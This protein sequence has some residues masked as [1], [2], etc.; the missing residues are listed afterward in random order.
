MKKCPSESSELVN[1]LDTENRTVMRLF[2]DLHTLHTE[3]SSQYH[4]ARLAAAKVKLTSL[5][6]DES[7]GTVFVKV[8]GR[9]KCCPSNQ[10]SNT[11]T[12]ICRQQKHFWPSASTSLKFA[13]A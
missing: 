1:K 11:Y 3:D 9:A 8:R 10:S 4:A 6:G 5:A 13:G 7:K 2:N 12:R